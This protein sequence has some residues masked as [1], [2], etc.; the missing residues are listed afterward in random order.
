MRRVI[1]TGDDFGLAVPVNEAI[2]EAHRSGVL[3]AAS[4]MVGGAA[5]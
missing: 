3:T 1:L 2:E 5:A 4:L